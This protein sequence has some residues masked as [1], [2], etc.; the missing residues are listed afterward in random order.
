MFNKNKFMI[1]YAKYEFPTDVWTQ[2]KSVICVDDTFINCDVVE[3][4]YP[5]KEVNAEGVCITPNTKIAVD[6]MWREEPLEEFSTY[7]VFPNPPGAHSFAGQ[8]WLYT[9][10]FCD[11]NPLSPYCQISE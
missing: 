10:R 1:V 5:C 9:Q 4:V 2:L 11:F 3:N 7:E 8:D 6:I